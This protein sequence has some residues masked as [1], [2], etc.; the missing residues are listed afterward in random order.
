MPCYDQLA[1]VPAEQVSC[2]AERVRHMKMDQIR[3][4]RSNRKRNLRADRRRT[5]RQGSCQLSYWNS[6]QDL[7]SGPK[8]PSSA[9]SLAYVESRVQRLAKSMHVNLH[10]TDIRNSIRRS[11]EDAI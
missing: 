11:I 3:F 4:A 9:T 7:S 6:F 10:T 8:T 2:R 5:K 1:L